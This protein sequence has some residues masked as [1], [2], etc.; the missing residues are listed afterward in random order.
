MTIVLYVAAIVAANVITARTVPAEIGPFVVAWGTWFIAAT[1]FIRDVVQV[2]YGRAVAYAAI[3]VALVTSA[4]LSAALGDTL[5][6]VVGSALA[7][8]VS[9]TLDTEVFTRLRATV[10]TRVAISG[11][12]GGIF[13]SSIFVVVGLYASGIIPA[14]A[15][16]N[17]ILGQ[18]LVKA[19]VQLVAAGGW[20]AIRGPEALPE[21]AR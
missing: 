12:V 9:E 11:L 19:A 1:F 7:F 4:V 20:R 21:S 10:P 15:V 18:Y 17:A 5:L 14:S 6:V 3:A 8:A 16:P 13:D 2:R